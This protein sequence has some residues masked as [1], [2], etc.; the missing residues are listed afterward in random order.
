MGVG[1]RAKDLAVMSPMLL[2][3]NTVHVKQLLSVDDRHSNGSSFWLGNSRCAPES[4]FA[5]QLV[6]ILC[7]STDGQ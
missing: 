3:N 2:C 7:L 1:D 5:E 4:S 6:D